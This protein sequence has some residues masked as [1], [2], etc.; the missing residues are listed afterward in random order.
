MHQDGPLSDLLISWQAENF[1]D[2]QL[3]TLGAKYDS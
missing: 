1:D 3:A 2:E